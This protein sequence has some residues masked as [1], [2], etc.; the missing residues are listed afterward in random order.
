MDTQKSEEVF[1]LPHRPVILESAESTKLRIVYDAS[2]KA[3]KNSPSLN[4]CLETDPPLQNLL[5]NI[6]VRSR[7]RPIILCRDIQKAFWQILSREGVQLEFLQVRSS[8]TFRQLSSSNKSINKI[9][10]PRAIRLRWESVISIGL[11]LFGDASILGNCA[12]VY[13]VVYQPSITNKGLLVSKFR[14]SKEDVTIARLELVSA[15]YGLKFSIQ[16]IGS[17]ENGEHNI[18]SSADR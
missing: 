5:Y 17:T 14:L 15:Q 2:A 12:A 1:Y 10:L 13:A 6:L 7:M 18:S 11:Y 8:L 9:E 16:C 4:E 3:S